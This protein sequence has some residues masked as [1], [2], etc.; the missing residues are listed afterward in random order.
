MSSFYSFET[1]ST[2]YHREQTILKCLKTRFLVETV[3]REF[4]NPGINWATRELNT[5][6]W[7]NNNNHNIDGGCR[8]IATPQ[9][10]PQRVVV[11]G[12]ALFQG[13]CQRSDPMWNLLLLIPEY[14]HMLADL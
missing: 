11:G 6:Y 9:T 8:V 3:A 10:P 7:C 12:F 1:A 4:R 5:S 13:P 14:V 2:F